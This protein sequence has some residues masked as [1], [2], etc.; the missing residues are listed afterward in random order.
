M[1]EVNFKLNGIVSDGKYTKEFTDTLQS[2]L[3]ESKK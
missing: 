3:E 1:S 2:L